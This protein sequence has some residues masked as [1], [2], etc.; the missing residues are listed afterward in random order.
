MVSEVVLPVL[1]EQPANRVLDGDHREAESF[2]HVDFAGA[3][4]E[5]TTF[6]SC[7]F[8]RTDLHDA[9]L[10][11]AHFVDSVLSDLDVASLTAPRS[12]WRRVRLSGSRIGALETYESSFRSVTVEGSKLG[13][14]NARSSVWQDVE[15]TDCVI[16]ELDLGSAI[17][18]RVKF[19]RCT[20]KTLD[21]T[22][23]KLSDVDLRGASLHM[24][25]GLDGL[26]GTWIDEHQLGDLAPLFATHLEI[27]VSPASS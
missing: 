25:K 13:F 3:D 21:L 26:R 8:V 17:A 6:G 2:D 18:S 23:A 7:R 27:N 12:S 5:F 24:I 1:T 14:V 19:S 16:D 10:R 15:F 9:R 11:G 20:I 22:R 4:L